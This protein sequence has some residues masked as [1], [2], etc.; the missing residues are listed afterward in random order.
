MDGAVKAGGSTGSSAV[1]QFRVQGLG[2]RVKG[3]GLTE[4]PKPIP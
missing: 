2:S 4:L 1:K 3:F